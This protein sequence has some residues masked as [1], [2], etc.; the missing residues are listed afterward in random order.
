MATQGSVVAVDISAL[1]AQ[2]FDHRE[3]LPRAR[4]VAQ[5]VA[6]FLPGSAVAIYLL[7]TIDD[8]Q[9]WAPQTTV[10]DLTIPESA[11][12]TGEARTCCASIMLT[13]TRGV[14]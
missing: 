7:A 9:A 10:G 3:V 14:R 4:I 8:G 11:V 12:S 2:L 6:E 5:A 1:S 13:C